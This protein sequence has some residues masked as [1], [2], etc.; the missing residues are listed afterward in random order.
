MLGAYPTFTHA[1]VLSMVT[2]PDAQPSPMRVVHLF[3]DLSNLWFSAREEA[4]AR[5]ELELALRLHAEHLWQL[6]SAGRQVETAILVANCELP[7]AALAFYRRFFE[8][9][10]VEPGLRSGT[11]QAGDEMLQN[12]IYRTIGRPG[13]SGTIVLVTG[14][15]AGWIQGRGFCPALAEAR[16]R[17]FG[18][19]VLAFTRSTNRHLRALAET[20][21]VYLPL[22]DFYSSI[23]FVER[24]RWATPVDLQHRTITLARRLSGVRRQVVLDVLAGLPTD[25]GDAKLRMLERLHPP[26]RRDMD[27]WVEH[28]ALVRTEWERTRTDQAPFDTTDLLNEA[29]DRVG[30]PP[31]RRRPMVRYLKYLLARVVQQQ[32]ASPP[33]TS[34]AA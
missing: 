1:E 18:V 34:V 3:I 6:L 21:G 8:V 31:W 16:L 23:T 19:E 2:K 15:G 25:V 29:L 12:A 13:A 5:G 33:T 4:R 26:V 28:V 24:A 22:E 32:T 10:L 30:L 11:E 14:D 7:T 9:I 20:I 17:G 27:D